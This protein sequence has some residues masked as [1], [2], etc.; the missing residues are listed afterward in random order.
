MRLAYKTPVRTGVELFVVFS[1][2][3]FISGGLT[4]SFG[5]L[6]P[7]QA[8]CKLT[9]EAKSE[10]VNGEKVA[11]GLANAFL[12]DAEI[13]ALCNFADQETAPILNLVSLHRVAVAKSRAVGV[14]EGASRAG[15][16]APG[17]TTAPA[18]TSKGDNPAIPRDAGTDA[19]GATG[20]VP[21]KSG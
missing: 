10:I 16:C 19:K 12:S 14:T 13:K 20:L 21:P 4:T 17:V 15:A 6:V 3:G 18:S 9:P 7:P 5:G 2:L 8:G 1:L 11:C